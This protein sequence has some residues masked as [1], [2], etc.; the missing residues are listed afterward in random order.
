MLILKFKSCDF[1]VD[2][3]LGISYQIGFLFFFSLEMFSFLE[4]L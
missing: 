4:F 2:E 3:C 1:E